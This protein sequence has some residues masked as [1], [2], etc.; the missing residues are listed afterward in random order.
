MIKIANGL[1]IEAEAAGAFFREMTETEMETTIRELNELGVNTLNIEKQLA[2]QKVATSEKAVIGI[3]NEKLLREDLADFDKTS[4]DLLREKADEQLRL[5]NIYGSQEQIQSTINNLTT[6]IALNSTAT[7]QNNWQSNKA[8][9]ASQKS[10]RDLLE[11]ELK[12]I[13]AIDSELAA[14]EISRLLAKEELSFHEKL[15]LSKLQL[16][17]I[18]EEIA[19]LA[20]PEEEMKRTLTQIN[21]DMK[22]LKASEALLVLNKELS[23]VESQRNILAQLKADL[24]EKIASDLIDA[25]GLKE[26]ELN[27][28]KLEMSID[29][30]VFENKMKL[31][32][33]TIDSME[34]VTSALASNL[35]RRQ[36]EELK[37]F[38]AEAGFKNASD[39]GQLRMEEN[40]NKEW[41]KKRKKLFYAEQTAAVANIAINTAKGIAHETGKTGIFGLTVLGSAI[42][43]SGALQT[44][45]V[46]AQKPPEY[47]YGGMVGGQR[48]SAG[49]TLIEAEQGEF[50]MNRNAVDSIGVGALNAMN[51]SGAGVTVN[52]SGNVLTQDF[53]E[54]E[55]A[56]SIQE[57]VRKG[58]SFA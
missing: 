50:V 49:G 56:E 24:D 29:N 14:N 51:Q 3:K 55:L 6:S 4:R 42:L 43:A 34:Q 46:L 48:H 32:S 1:K 22:Q 37:A 30:E 11:N 17:K 57:A 16:K 47:E 52:I 12:R 54:G 53:V 41:N 36:A 20:K 2:E 44:A 5:N 35:D 26:D 9:V 39:A 15:I 7:Q 10:A 40:F 28:K 38:K 31:A 25:A 19:N 21:L 13:K 33:M 45:L 27:I 58:V 18:E 23:S 8:L